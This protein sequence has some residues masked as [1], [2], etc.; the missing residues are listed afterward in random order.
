MKLVIATKNQHKLKEIQ[1]IL[2]DLPEYELISL[3]DYP[4]APDV[5]EDQDSFVGNAGKKALELA[6]YTGELTMADDSGLE[7][8][9]LN[10]EPGVYSARYAGA[11][12]TYK[13]L[14][15]KLLKNM[16]NIPAPE[17]TAQF[18]SV[19]AV[20]SPEKVLFTV[21]GICPGKIIHEM[22]GEHGFGYDPVF[23]YEPANKTFAELS[24][25]EKNEISHRARA[26][27]KLAEML[28]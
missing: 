12:A 14:C 19:I 2:K 3:S 26:L 6:R 9:A 15:E 25:E 1:Q 27:K 5:I 10:G 23:L 24:A 21:E 28:K 22:R 20:A 7:V 17:R 13:Q 16:E 18:K 8:D 4:N 11:G